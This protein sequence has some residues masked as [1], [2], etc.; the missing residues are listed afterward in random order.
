M[1]SVSR[2][3]AL[4]LVLCAAIASPPSVSGVQTG[5]G[6]A[7][8]AA[9][10][11]FRCPED[12]GSEAAQHQALDD[13]IKTYTAQHPNASVQELMLVRGRLL[14]SH[15]CTQTLQHMLAHVSAIAQM[16]RFSGQNY[17]RKET[18]FDS[19][20]H[21]WTVY[22]DPEAGEP[23]NP[24]HGLIFNFYGWNAN[25]SARS[26]AEAWMN[27][28]DG[29]RTIFKFQ[30]PDEVTRLPAFFIVSETM[31]ADRGYGYVNISKIASAGS[32]AYAV[33][34]DRRFAG[35]TPAE[36]DGSVRAW[37]LTSEAKEVQ[38][39]IAGVGIEP[40]WQEALNHSH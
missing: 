23:T 11:D 5:P 27:R 40:D 8:P 3:G 29:V 15:H 2:F 36:V 22:F 32:G 34:Y 1:T 25:A 6:G 39:A 10:S 28:T 12:Y 17:D 20:T 24:D 9:I 21:V 7:Q 37:L 18:K 33:T 31:H 19:A 26:V 13:F 38:K 30:A 16:L 14:V 35:N 4:P